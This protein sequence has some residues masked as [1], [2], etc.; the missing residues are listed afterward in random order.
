MQINFVVNARKAGDTTCD[1]FFPLLLPEP[2]RQP[3]LANQSSFRYENNC[4]F[5]INCANF[6]GKM[7]KKKKTISGGN[8]SSSQDKKLPTYLL[9]F[10]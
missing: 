5:I 9:H 4:G 6:N 10:E 7:S 3:Q 2:T 1:F 8:K